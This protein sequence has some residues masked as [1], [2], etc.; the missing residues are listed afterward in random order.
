MA[1]THSETDEMTRVVARIQTGVLALTSALIGGI[2]LFVITAWLLIQGGPRV[3][4]HLQLLGQ[5][6]V[7]YSVTWKGSVV[8]LFYGALIGGM[9]GWAVGAIYN[10]I[11]SL[12]QG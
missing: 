10:W 12:R 11:V 4:E 2:G 7:G 3:G 8:G 1:R 5:Y 6:F 9:V